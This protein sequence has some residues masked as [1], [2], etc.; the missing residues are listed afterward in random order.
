MENKEG[1]LYALSMQDKF[2]FT[3]C[4][5]NEYPRP[6]FKRDSYICLNGL[7][8]FQMKKDEDLPLSYSE[9]ILVPYAVESHL[10]GIERLVKEDDV[11]FYHRVITLPDDYVD[12]NIIINFDG[13]DQIG[14][15]YIDR[16]LVLIT[17]DPYLR[18]QLFIKKAKKEFDL[19][20]QVRDYTDK[21]YYQRGKQTTKR[22]GYFYTSSSGIYRPVWIEKVP[23]KY[24]KEI[25]IRPLFDEKKI[26][27]LVKSDCEGK[28]KVR[29]DEK[30]FFIQA[31][32]EEYL[33][34]ENFHPYFLETPYIYDIKFSFYEDEVSSLFAM[35]KTSIENK[36]GY[37]RFAINNKITFL[38]GILYQGYYYLGNLTPLSNDDMYQDLKKIKD[39]GFNMIRVHVK[40]EAD[41]FYY[42][43]I[44]LGLYIFQDFP[45]G[46]ERYSFLPTVLPRVFPFL[47]NERVCSFFFKGLGRKSTVSKEIFQKDAINYLSHLSNVPNIVSYSIFN[48]GWGEF[49][50]SYI[51]L[52]L[53]EIYPDILFDTS[54]G[55]Y[56]C[57]SDYYSIHTYTFP[58]MKREDKTRCFI[59]SEMGGIGYREQMHSL[60]KNYFAHK[61]CKDKITYE[62]KI[63]KLYEKDLYFHKRRGLSMI[64][65]TQFN[66]VEGEY[67]GL[68]TFDRDVLKVDIELIRKLNN[69]MINC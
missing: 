9:K 54:S 57:K 21:S 22:N 63:K 13:I 18:H 15:I 16:K 14:K 30:N 11:L 25:S 36:G 19:V 55:W 31:N 43:A 40:I 28:V 6:F 67:N 27:V 5:L 68:Y 59:I 66:D 52:K 53:K 10:S 49:H 45:N 33:P 38:S 34:V 1:Y 41:L 23:D 4:P 20:I 51:Y 65:Y 42:Y 64:V 26:K 12:K 50:P 60:F 56:D 3:D 47:S 29:F 46:G 17:D 62:K 58:R 8:D 39:M 32:K 24:I 69:K 61:K 2:P 35:I 48:E 7:W 44:R 37:K